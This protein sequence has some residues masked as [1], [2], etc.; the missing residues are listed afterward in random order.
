MPA[1]FRLPGDAPTVNETP[2]QVFVGP[3]TPWAGDG[4]TGPRYPASFLDGTSNT[5]L[6]AEAVAK[7]P[8]TKPVDMP[9]RPGLS[10]LRL[11]GSK[12]FPGVFYAAMADV[13]VKK[14]PLTI[15]EK[16]LRDAINPADNN[17]LGPD[18]PAK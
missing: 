16:T 13:T 17:P 11:V 1:I 10:P 5:I 14:V 15:K 18:W 2:Y 8:W 12:A 6:L 4:R 7:V 9:L 3:G